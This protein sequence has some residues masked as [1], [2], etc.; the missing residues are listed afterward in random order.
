MFMVNSINNKDSK[1][2]H[3]ESHITF[4]DNTI[5]QISIVVSFYFSDETADHSRKAER[6]QKMDDTK[7]R[8]GVSYY[9]FSI[10]NP[11]IGI[12]YSGGI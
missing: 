8:L 11:K 12:S 10:T 3:P 5:T 9:V 4:V 1:L 2:N 7:T 6:K